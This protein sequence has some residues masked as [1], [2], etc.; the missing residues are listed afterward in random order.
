MT[1]LMVMGNNDWY[2]NKNWDDQIESAFRA[3]L[4]RSRG[5][6]YRTQYLRIQGS[7][8]LS[9]DTP[10]NHTVG[11]SLMK[12]VLT[13]YPDND[14]TIANKFDALSELG[15]YYFKRDRF[16]QAYEYYKKAIVLD[17]NHT[18]DQS[19]AILGHIKSAVLLKQQ[20]D[21]TYCES[22]LEKVGEP[23]FPAQ[24]YDL[25]LTFAMLYDAM[26][27][28][29]AAKQYAATALKASEQS[30]PFVRKGI[31]LGK[32]SI[33]EREFSFLTAIITLEK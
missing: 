9:S 18:P 12:E 27:C 8:L 23:V 24:A 32:A 20:Q 28:A 15:D 3:R 30:S 6:Y 17:A 33:A 10:A 29:E 7:Y 19:H 16:D 5:D 2:R 26:G 1:E 31:T 21:Y 11:L 22:L 13:E 25:Y 14:D 4:K